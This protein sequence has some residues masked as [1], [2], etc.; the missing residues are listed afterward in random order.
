[1]QCQYPQHFDILKWIVK[2]RPQCR[3]PV[4][5]LHQGTETIKK[6]Y[7]KDLST[8]YQTNN[9]TGTASAVED[10]SAVVQTAHDPYRA[11]RFRDFRLLL[12]GNFIAVIGEQ[13]LT[14][15]IGWELYDRTN[16]ALALGGVGLAQVI[17]V[18]LFSLPAGHVADRFNRKNIVV[19]STLVLLLASLVLALLSFTHGALPL[20][21]TCLALIGTAEAFNNPASSTL[22]AQVV[23]EDAFENAT[24]W[25]SSSWQL[26]SV[27]GP[28]LGGFLIAL[29]QGASWVYVA[30]AGTM[31][32]FVILLLMLRTRGQKRLPASEKATLRS[33]IEGL[34]FLR[35]NQIVLAAITLD[36]FAVLLGGATTLLPIYAR[37]ILQV[38]PTGLGWLRAAPSVGAVCMAL[39]L[40]HRP[41]F[42]RGGRALLL[43]VAGFGLATIIFGLSR[44]FWLSLL[45]LFALGALDNISV[46]I[47]HTLLLLRTPDEMRGRI[48]AVSSLFISAS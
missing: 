33:L 32:V 5:R 48:S 24:T 18:I 40:A 41:P 47:R 26:A 21:Y 30:N 8:V 43:A 9:E 44:S 34:G 2:A 22:E 6:F 12:I 17:P 7:S 19:I 10:E 16:S 14:V 11:L 1:M 36:L 42:K 29:T 45:M 3:P 15:A 25:S 23:P 13:M 27:L 35:G 28:G 20:I 4:R 37:D 38:G 39:L 31:L 46:V